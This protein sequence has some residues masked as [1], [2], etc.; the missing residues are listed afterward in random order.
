M[1]ERPVEKNE[2]DRTGDT[3][4]QK[5]KETSE[6]NWEERVVKKGR[7]NEKKRY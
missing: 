7:K 3:K 5:R 4:N 1:K 2:E 6:E